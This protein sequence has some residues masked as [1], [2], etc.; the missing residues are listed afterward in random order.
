MLKHGLVHVCVYAFVLFFSN[1]TVATTYDCGN[2]CS[3]TTCFN[4]EAVLQYKL[5]SFPKFSQATE[6]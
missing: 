1:T 2:A 5:T 6:R 4:D 3:M